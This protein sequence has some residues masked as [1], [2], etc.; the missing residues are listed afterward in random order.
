M[1]LPQPT[2]RQP[3]GLLIRL[4]ALLALLA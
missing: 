4:G 3:K 2:T 1:L